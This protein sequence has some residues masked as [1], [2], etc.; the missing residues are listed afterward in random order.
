MQKNP[1]T[2]VSYW[3]LVASHF[4]PIKT[5]IALDSGISDMAAC[6]GASVLQPSHGNTKL[7]LIL[8]AVNSK[9]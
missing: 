1:W 8:L 2:P 5:P 3:T 6:T 9:R 4:F 7:Y